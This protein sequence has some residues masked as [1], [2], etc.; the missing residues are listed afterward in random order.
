MFDKFDISVILTTLYPFPLQSYFHT[1]YIW[2]LGY[3]CPFGIYFL[4]DCP[5]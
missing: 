1:N 3:E 4:L 5:R 2:E